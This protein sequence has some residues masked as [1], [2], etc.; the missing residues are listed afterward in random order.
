MAG[1]STT[2]KRPMFSSEMDPSSAWAQM[3]QQNAPALDEEDMDAAN[4]GLQAGPPVGM[5]KPT[6]TKTSVSVTKRTRPDDPQAQD[7]QSDIL[8]L[9]QRFGDQSD[10]ALKSQQGGVDQLQNYINQY[11]NSPQQV[12][13]SPLAAYV[14]SIVPGSNISKGYNAPEN[15]QQRQ[16]KMMALNEE[17]QKRREGFSKSQAQLLKDQIDAYKAVKV[18]DLDNTLKMAKI[19]FYN[20]ALP[21]QQNQIDERNYAQILQ[22]IKK[23]PIL[24]QQIQPYANLSNSLDLVTKPDKTPEQQFNELQQTIRGST[25]LRG[26]SGVGER[27]DDY[28]K[29][30]GSKGA[31]WEQYLS[32]KITNIPEATKQDMI[33]HLGQ[34]VQIEKSNIERQALGRFQQLSSGQ[35][36]VLARD[37]SKKKD[38]DKFTS[39]YFNGLKSMS[40]SGSDADGGYKPGEVVNGYKYKGGGYNNQSNWEKVQ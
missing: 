8:N 9:M 2:T 14:D 40:D 15:P 39:E 11:A 36:R 23:D 21:R 37:P 18:G 5:P 31:T 25:G 13:L 34:I 28:I 29:T 6:K 24:Q 38:F 7:A 17:L 32:G 20:S 27:Q 19:N 1:Y 30:F 12:N 16:E 26:K 22:D 10:A 4:M 35:D 3:L 33:T